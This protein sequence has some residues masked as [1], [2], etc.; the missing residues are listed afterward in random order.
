MSQSPVAAPS[1]PVLQMLIATTSIHAF[2][3]PQALDA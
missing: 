1:R 3:W 2:L